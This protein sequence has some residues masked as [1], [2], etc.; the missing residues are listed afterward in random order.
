[1]SVGRR[2]SSKSSKSGT[3]RNGLTLIFI[4][5]PLRILSRFTIFTLKS[6]SLSLYLFYLSRPFSRPFVSILKNM[7]LFFIFR[8][9]RSSC[10]NVRISTSHKK[11]T[12]HADVIVG[13]KDKSSRIKISPWL[14]WGKW[15]L[16]TQ[17]FLSNM[18]Q[19]TLI[20][21]L[22]QSLSFQ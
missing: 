15:N 2:S 4:S 5:I 6:L 10:D 1:M 3:D 13:L 20:F 14:T 17:N 8:T 16:H 19:V 9:E 18:Q 12:Y 21:H 22:S 11:Y 7:S